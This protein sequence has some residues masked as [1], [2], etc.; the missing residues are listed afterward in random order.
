MKERIVTIG[1]CN[2]QQQESKGKNI[3]ESILKNF[4]ILHYG[5]ENPTSED[6]A[7]W[8][9]WF[10]SIADIQVDRGG[11]RDGL[12]ITQSGTNELPFTKDSITGYTIIEANNLDE[13]EKIAEECPVVHSTRVYEISKG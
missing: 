13:A 4:L 12:E 11:L 2:R 3:E 1:S 8:N 10:N 6:M 5:F 9:K 7:A